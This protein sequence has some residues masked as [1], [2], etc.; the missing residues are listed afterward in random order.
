MA[1]G[2]RGTD[3]QTEQRTVVGG[4]KQTFIGRFVTAVR[5]A[6]N[7]CMA[8]SNKDGDLAPEPDTGGDEGAWR[9]LKGFF[10]EKYPEMTKFL[11]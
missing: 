2:Q 1:P 10:L 6:I 5:F 9:G 7:Y 3:H 4:I 8:K 11:I